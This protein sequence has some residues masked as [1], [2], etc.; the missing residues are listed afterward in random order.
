MMCHPT[1]GT[2]EPKFR[3]ILF[4]RRSWLSP[5]TVSSSLIPTK[6]GALSL[7]FF[8]LIHCSG[9]D[10]WVYLV[11]DGLAGIF[12]LRLD[13]FRQTAS[14]HPLVCW[15]QLNSESPVVPGDWA[16]DRLK[17]GE[18]A[19]GLETGPWTR[20]LSI[21]LVT[22]HVN[23]CSALDRYF[24]DNLLQVKWIIKV[25]VATLEN[26][27]LITSSQ[28]RERLVVLVTCKRC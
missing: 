22:R 8:F 21:E 18:P 20:R 23:L 28:R 1:K 26:S 27:L 24:L 19:I 16:W 9:L 5:H 11:R 4:G 13:L 6:A 7:F 14:T 2:K 12:A 25:V 10:G 17:D 3:S 15:Q